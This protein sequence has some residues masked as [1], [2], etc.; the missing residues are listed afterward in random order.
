MNIYREDAEAAAETS[1]ETLSPETR[2]RLKIVLK[3]RMEEKE[4]EERRTGERRA[5]ERRTGDRR[6]GERR[7][8]ERRRKKG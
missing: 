5:E 7:T 1:S 6:A 2:E 3:K 8:E 4:T